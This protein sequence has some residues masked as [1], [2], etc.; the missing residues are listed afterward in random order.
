M[1]ALIA[2]LFFLFYLLVP[3]GIFR[4]ATSLAVPLKKFHKTKTQEITFAVVACFAP[5]W[6]TMALV[7]SVARCPFS[8]NYE[9]NH[10][11]RE[12]YRTVFAG[13]N[14]DKALETLNGQHMFWPAVDSVLRR[15]AR[16]LLWY[17]VLVTAEAAGLWWVV[18]RHRRF[19][20]KRIY[21]FF[22][23]HFLIPS[24][25]EWHVILTDFA[26]PVSPPREIAVDVLTTERILYQGKMNDYFLNSEGELSGILLSQALKFEGDELAEDRHADLEVRV[27]C[28]SA[29][30]NP[31]TETAEHKKFTRQR[32]EYWRLI[33]GADLFYLPKERISN[34]NVRHVAPSIPK[35]AAARLQERGLRVGI[36]EEPPNPPP[37]SQT[38]P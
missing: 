2:S 37:A 11:R 18:S 16:F 29:P 26:V 21:D 12:A 23:D 15:Q 25:S 36:S 31:S 38:L 17:Y 28:L 24:I 3:G 20:G 5:F 30:S 32:S 10:Q 7:W 22:A 6:L 14:S 9:N 1:I 13:L 19:T 33:D 4:F 35:A 27:S 8:T 34:L